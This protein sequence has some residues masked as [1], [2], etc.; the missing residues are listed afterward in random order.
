MC[1]R[2]SIAVRIGDLAE[3]F[4]IS[5]PKGLVLPM[6]NIAPGENVPVITTTTGLVCLLMKWGLVPSWSKGEKPDLAPI[7]ARAEGLMEKPLFRGLVS[8]GRCI[9]PA[10]G[11]YEWKKNGREKVPVY[12]RMKDDEVFGM[13]GLCSSR[14]APDGR[15]TW[16]FTIITTSPNSVVLPVH[17]RM[18]AILDQDLQE[19]WLDMA[20]PVSAELPE[21]LKPYPPDRMVAY[22][23][24]KQVN[25]PS[26]KSEAAVTKDMQQDFSLS[27]WEP[28]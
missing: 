17:T 18:P 3:Q 2:F 22:R 15:I 13:A 8:H 21:I 24:T 10:T 19:G 12:F 16:S 23:V 6:Y 20:S 7:N 27:G 5:E 11:F 26:F 14:K 25:S 4:G 9:V 1:G 28:R